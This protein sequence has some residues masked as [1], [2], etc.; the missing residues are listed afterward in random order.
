MASIA[1]LGYGVVGTGTA[2]LINKNKERFKKITGEELKLSN[3]LVRNI[4]KHKEKKNSKILTDNFD[5]ILKSPVDI[6][7]EVMGGVNPAYKYVKKALTS[8]KHVVTANKDLMAEHGKELLDLAYENGVTLNFEA[9]VGGGIPILKPL[10]ECLT[11]NEIVS[12][13]AILNGTTNLMLSKMYNENMNYEEALKIAQDLGFAEAN[14]DSDVLGYDAARKLSILSTI[15]YD[16]KV[17]WKDV[18]IQGITDIDADDFKYAKANGYNIKLLAISKKEDDGIFASVQ[19]VIVDKNS[20]LSKIENEV[21]AIVIKGDAVG[22]VVFS[23]KGAGMFPT[24]SAVFGDIA[25]I[26]QNKNKRSIKFNN[27]NANIQKLYNY[28]SSWLI[29]LKTTDK[30][31]TM[32]NLTGSFKNCHIFKNDLNPQNEVIAIIKE[33]TENDLNCKLKNLEASKHVQHIKKFLHIK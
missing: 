19:P 8:K 30:I 4:E 23:G 29:R 15:A 3:I 26:I 5:H 25:D 6:I 20:E 14:P 13:K 33:E 27:E 9:S 28:K 2:E 32:C 18:H 22:D 16:K 31:D 1:I 7:V 11:G 12:I 21:N 17:N 24:A 10:M